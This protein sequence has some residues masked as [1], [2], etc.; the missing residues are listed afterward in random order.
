LTAEYASLFRL[1]DTFDRAIAPRANTDLVK[2][3]M[4][5]METKPIFGIDS[6]ITDA[7][8]KLQN[9]RAKALQRQYGGDNNE[10]VG[11]KAQ[12]DRAHI[13]CHLCGQMG[14]FQAKCPNKGGKFQYGKGKGFSGG[15]GPGKGGKGG[16]ARPFY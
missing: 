6:E 2:L 9:D 4:G 11:G 13:M 3:H 14:H 7:Q 16:V 8:L 15:K 10:K 5:L 12:K 1:L